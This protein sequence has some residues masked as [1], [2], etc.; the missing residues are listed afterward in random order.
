[1]LPAKVSG[2]QEVR[3]IVEENKSAFDQGL[4]SILHEG[5]LS[6]QVGL[7]RQASVTADSLHS[8]SPQL[9]YTVEQ[10][11]SKTV[12]SLHGSSRLVHRCFTEGYIRCRLEGR[13]QQNTSNFCN[14]VQFG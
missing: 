12:A 6:V 8:A 11:K 9:R 2:V 7:S 3:L 14:N 4:F 13:R 1:M 10:M 5:E